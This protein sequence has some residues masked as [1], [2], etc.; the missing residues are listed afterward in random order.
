[1]EDESSRFLPGRRKPRPRIA[2]GLNLSTASADHSNTA[3]SKV[4]AVAGSQGFE[5]FA[6]LSLYPLRATRPRA[7]PLRVEA[8]L[9]QENLIRI[10]AFSM[11]VSSFMQPV[12]WDAW[13]THHL[14]SV[15][16]GIIIRAHEGTS[17]T[18]MPLAALLGTHLSRPPEAPIQGAAF[19]ELLRHANR[20]IHHVASIERCLRGKGLPT[21][22]V[23][24]RRSATPIAM[25][26]QHK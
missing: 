15:S 11:L 19:V 20:L 1:M 14:A 10:E 16:D 18:S 2:V 3:V 4:E 17:A 26:P 5:G 12:L 24:A 6:M 13:K 21:A 9:I 22:N 23:Q 7:F 25:R 8:D